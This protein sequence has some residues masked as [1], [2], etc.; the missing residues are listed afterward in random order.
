MTVQFGAEPVR[1]A[2]PAVSQW[3]VDFSSALENRTG[4]YFIGR[5]L[6]SDQQRH[7]RRVYY[8]RLGTAQH[9]MGSALRLLSPALRIEARGRSLLGSAFGPLRRSS[10]P[11][12]H[13]DPF[14]V[15][16]TAVSA[17][18]MVVCHDLGPITHPDLFRPW[19]GQ[20]Y[21][22]AYRRIADA[23]ARIVF[24]SAATSEEFRRLFGENSRTTVIYPP[25]RSD[26][27]SG[28]DAVVAELAGRQFL[29]TVGSI[30]RRK[31][32]AASIRA[33]ARSGLAARGVDYVLCGAREPGA[34]EVERLA[35]ATPGVRLLP[36]VS[37]EQLRWL[38]RN[39]LGF[40][41]VSR[42]EGFGVPVAEAISWGLVP[43]VTGNSVLE[44]VAGDG[45]LVSDCD[46][47]VQIAD[48]M[49]RLCDMAPDERSTRSTTMRASLHRFTK[50][51]FASAWEHE[52]TLP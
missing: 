10:L 28:A 15:M 16:H 37:G 42:L 41:L 12:L 26:I 2:S 3:D 32:Q 49:T 18:D 43:L 38:Y 11:I 5:D 7:I 40:V 48:G 51:S 45:A 6:I 35:E 17:R 30:G 29:L 19:V 33:F 13:L 52:L 34:G 8:W 14:S 47:E 36:Y 4:K 25:L 50:A 46:D 20:L 21:R 31:N 44:E 27:R 23:D 9:T 1:A 22:R 39:A 24:V